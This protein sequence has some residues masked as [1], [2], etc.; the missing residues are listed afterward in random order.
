MLALLLSTFMLPMT[1]YGQPTVKEELGKIYVRHDQI[2]IDVQGLFAEI[3][4]T[5]V[6]V[7]L[8][9]TDA[10]GFYV[11]HRNPD[12]HTLRCTRCNFINAYWDDFCQGQWGNGKC[13]APRPPK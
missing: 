4:G 5:W 6:P 9:A 7:E 11:G 12:Y 1:S 3:E 10:H 13:F 8:V 2:L